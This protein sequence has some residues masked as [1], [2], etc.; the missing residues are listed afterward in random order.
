MAATDELQD[1]SGVGT[2]E[3]TSVRFVFISR[4]SPLGAPHRLGFRTDW[5]SAPIGVPHRLGFRTGWEPAP[6]VVPHR[7]GV[8]TDWESAPVGIPHRL[9]FRTGCVAFM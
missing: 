3:D 5:E 6:I 8:R 1:Q 7:L 4:Y 9:G 2:S